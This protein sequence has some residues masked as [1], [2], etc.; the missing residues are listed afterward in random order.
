MEVTVVWIVKGRVVVGI[1]HVLAEDMLE[2]MGRIAV[3]NMVSDAT[4]VTRQRQE[5][6]MGSVWGHCS[7]LRVLKG[8]IV[9]VVVR[10]ELV[11][12]LRYYCLMSAGSLEVIS[13]PT[14]SA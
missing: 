4:Q 8:G 6:H 1:A 3:V 13:A 14:R 5:R 2:L 7:G 10:S 9:D 12:G 11:E